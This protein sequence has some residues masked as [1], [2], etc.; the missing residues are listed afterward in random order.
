M[1]FQRRRF[2]DAGASDAPCAEPCHRCS[3]AALVQANQMLRR[4]RADA[5]DELLAAF[6]VGFRVALGGV[7]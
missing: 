7:Q 2:L 1:A 4:D 5:L 6:T 3:H